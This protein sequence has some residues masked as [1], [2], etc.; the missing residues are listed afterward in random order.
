MISPL[1]ALPYKQLRVRDALIRAGYNK[2]AIVASYEYAAQNGHTYSE[3]ADLVAFSEADSSRFDVQ[4]ACVAFYQPGPAFNPAII[5]Q[6]YSNLAT[7]II[8]IDH[9]N[10]V[11]VWPGRSKLWRGPLKPLAIRSYDEIPNYF[12]ENATALG[13]RALIE[14]K[15]HSYQLSIFDIDS[16]LLEAALSATHKLLSVRFSE[17]LSQGVRLLVER[18]IDNDPAKSDLF[19]LALQLLAA[20]ILEDK[21][22]TAE[23]RSPSGIALLEKAARNY[24]ARFSAKVIKALDND[25][26]DAMAETLR[27]GATFRSCTIEMLGH[28]YEEALLSRTTKQEA[29]I[30]YTTRMLSR[31]ILENIP[32]EQIAPADRS[33]LDGTC[34]SGS[35]L[36][37]GYERLEAALPVKFNAH[38]R[39]QYLHPRIHGVDMDPIA[40]FAADFSLFL[41]SLSANSTS[42][43]GTTSTWD[44]RAKD[45][46]NMAPNDW[47]SDLVPPSILVGNPPFHEQSGEQR[48]VAFVQQYLR[49]LPNNGLLGLIL[50]ATFLENRSC[51]ETRRMLLKRCDLLDLWYLPEGEFP[52]SQV[53]TIVVLAKGQEPSARRDGPVRLNWWR[54]SP[55]ASVP[56]LT[57][58][59]PSQESWLKTKLAIMTS[60]ALGPAFWDNLG[61]A[62]TLGNIATVH[63][64]IKRD[65]GTFTPQKNTA[66]DRPWLS[67]TS[68]LQWYQVQW[69]LQPQMSRYVQW[70][71]TLKRPRLQLEAIFNGP[72]VLVNANRAPNNPWRI[73]AGLDRQGLFPSDGFTVIVPKEHEDGTLEE[74]VAVLNSPVASAWV[75]STN[76]ARRID[77]DALRDMPYPRFDPELRHRLHTIV[78]QLGSLE[79]RAMKSRLRDRIDSQPSPLLAGFLYQERLRLQAAIDNIV[80]DA[81][82]FG[83]EARA[84]LLDFFRGFKRKDHEGEN[85]ADH[86]PPPSD[87]SN[88]IKRPWLVSGQVLSVEAIANRLTLW[89]NGYNDNEPFTRPIPD[90]MP[91][92]ALRAGAT[93]EAFLPFEERW[94]P[95][96]ALDRMKSFRVPDY[97][98]LSQETLT[99]LVRQTASI[100]SLYGVGSIGSH[101]TS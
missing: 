20:A 92:W 47:N 69:D 29:G 11:E 93:F 82:R 16:T 95:V 73:Y 75:Q 54:R 83:P 9:H 57:R 89:L 3:T 90:S 2:D 63:N 87:T 19:R 25:I 62:G 4:R 7:P 26:A 45:F 21:Y 50:P 48:A 8:L 52:Q 74:L 77:T 18:H 33:V 30:Y 36:I 23:G 35:L 46:L 79:V 91:G 53:A 58:V 78:E 59:H 55:S 60:S 37:A 67:T 68:A 88:V 94:S 96:P 41:R 14:T 40:V 70:P 1:T 86:A 65:G 84:Q 56:T 15:Q 97:D 85:P 28:F 38:Q 22:W 17:A 61:N 32:V 81:F 31:R 27:H 101:A 34:G 72:K 99:G 43:G 80:L 5:T 64:G 12:A 13:P 39:L 42:E 24:P 6:R 71:G 66:F 98:A 44:V 10:S 49:W 76:I 100:E 51:A